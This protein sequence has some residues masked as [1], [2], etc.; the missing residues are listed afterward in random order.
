M[1]TQRAAILLKLLSGANTGAELELSPGDWTLG[2]SDEC[3]ILVLDAGVKPRH[4]MLRVSEAAALTLLPLEGVV[5]VEGLPVPP[6]GLDLLPFTIFTAGGV[7]ACCGPPD[8]AWPELS[9]PPLAVLQ[10][11]VEA[12]KEELPLPSVHEGRQ[13]DSGSESMERERVMPSAE[14]GMA[15]ES[16][17]KKL[18]KK[19]FLGSMG[20]AGRIALALTALL[21]LALILDFGTGGQFFTGSDDKSQKLTRLLHLN[22]FAQTQAVRDDTGTLRVIGTVVSN[23]RLDEL[24][25]F[26]TTLTPPPELAVISLE[27]VAL[28]LN[29]NFK[30]ADAAL[31]VSRGL[32]FLRI[33]GYAYDMRALESVLLNEWDKL[34]DVPV[35]LEALTWEAARP[36]LQRLLREK[37]LEAKGRFL[38][39]KYRITLQLQPLNAT[40][41]QALSVLLRQAE[42]L[43][44]VEGVI[45]TGRW[46][47]VQVVPPPPQPAATLRLPEP[48]LTNAIGLLNSTH[49]D[50]S[51]NAAFMEPAPGLENPGEGAGT[52]QEQPSL[53]ASQ[54]FSCSQIHITGQ[55]YDMGIIHQG[56]F[57]RLGARLPDG[58]QVRYVT[59]EL[60]VLQRGK[61]FTRICTAAETA[62]NKEKQR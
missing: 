21:L 34:K 19:G 36:E 25:V 11:E 6:E 12:E 43:F 5:T 62:A 33:S 8:A 7:H 1:N 59:P 58:L 17:P 48:F 31:S 18:T 13:E 50:V 52:A 14:I 57:Y 16:P 60:V 28:G 32:S 53:E 44:A 23:K 39:G 61:D 40:E 15:G 38:P 56:L 37:K 49:L 47:P 41:Q 10:K 54:V 51:P 3:H 24:V 46:Q 4:L 35:R 26:A 42:D 9:L 55:G 20:L 45:Q 2:S 29:A 22:G 30:R 27:D